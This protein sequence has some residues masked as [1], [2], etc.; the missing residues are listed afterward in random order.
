MTQ[1]TFSDS[2]QKTE[3]AISAGRIDDA[4]AQCQFIISHFPESLEA[5]RLLG[6]LYFAQGHLKEPRQT[7]DWFL[8]NDPRNAIAYCDRA[9]ISKRMSDFVTPLDGYN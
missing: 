8:T 1:T 4:L 6:E 7:F 3:D 5:L 2:L 9:K